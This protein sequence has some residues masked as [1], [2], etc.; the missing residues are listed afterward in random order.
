MQA[1]ALTSLSYGGQPLA[2]VYNTAITDLTATV[3]PTAAA[4]KVD[5]SIDP[6]LNSDTGLSF[7]T[8]SGR[9]SGTPTKLLTQQKSYTVTITGQT[10]TIYEG[11]TKD[12]SIQ[13]S[14]AQK[15]ISDTVFA[16]TF[17]DKS[18][19]NEGAAASHSAASFTT[20]GLTAATD[21]ELS[22]AGQAAL[23]YPPLLLTIAGISA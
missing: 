20:D 7:D 23:P 6:S 14:V 22:I 2:A 9:I 11:E 3:L 16:M 19:A 15:D 8:G 10:N 13:V 4:D 18:D 1:A 5:F 17:D 21:Y 12:V